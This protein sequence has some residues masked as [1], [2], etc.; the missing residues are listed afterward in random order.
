MTEQSGQCLCGAV[1][2]KAVPKSHEVGVCHCAMCR[3]N[4]AGPFFAIDCG[5]TL[6]FEDEANVGVYDS[7]DWAQRGFCKQCGSSLF[8]RLKDK[9][10]NIVAVDAFDDLGGLKLDHEVFID[11]KPGYYSFAEKTQQLTG[12]QVFEMFAADQGAH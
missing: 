8:W 7:S 2:F 1:K 6:V 9:S 4:N 11:E 12:Q 10:A 5:D 3:R